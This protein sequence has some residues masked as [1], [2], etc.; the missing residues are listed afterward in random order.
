M[1]VPF[2][3]DLAGRSGCVSLGRSVANGDGVCGDGCCSGIG[4][5]ARD[6][7]AAGTVDLSG[8]GNAFT[9]G[10]GESLYLAITGCCGVLFSLKTRMSKHKAKTIP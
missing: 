5:R 8:S 6:V 7:S 9:G 3:R 2:G 1:S 10:V 4:C